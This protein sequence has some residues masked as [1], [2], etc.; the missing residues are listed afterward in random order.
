MKT[1]LCY[2]DSNTHGYIPGEAG[3]YPRDVR[4]TGILQQELGQDFYVI[5]E[6]LNGRTTVWE[7]PIEEH[8][9]GKQYLPACL[10]S[11]APIDLVIIM[12]GTNDLKARFW[13]PASDIALGVGLLVDKTL[14]TQTGPDDSA[15]SVLVIAPPPLAKLTD[16]AEMLEGATEKSQRLAGLYQQV[17]EEYGCE[18][19][20]AASIAS[21]SDI[22]GVHMV[23][24]EHK[25]MGLGVAD[26]VR[27]IL[28]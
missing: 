5:E 15:P 27:Q 3:R 8:R 22:D 28:A 24:A 25:K 14:K 9:S 12:L 26:K 18:F 11:H 16:F 19:L 1:I 2:G 6:G 10:E 20:D 4:W 7:D 21:F 13:V 23:P 17:A